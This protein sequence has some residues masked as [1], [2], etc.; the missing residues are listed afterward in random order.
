MLYPIPNPLGACTVLTMISKRRPPS[1]SRARRTMEQGNGGRIERTER[2]NQARTVAD[3]GAGVCARSGTSQVPEDCRAADGIR[4]CWLVSAV[5]SF[6]AP[7]LQGLDRRRD[8]WAGKPQEDCAED[9]SCMGIATMI[10]LLLG[11]SSAR[12]GYSVAMIISFPFSLRWMDVK[13]LKVTGWA[14]KSG[15]CRSGGDGGSGKAH[16]QASDSPT[17]RSARTRQ[18][19][20]GPACHLR[21]IGSHVDGITLQR[22]PDDHCAARDGIST[23]LASWI[24]VL[25]LSS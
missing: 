9:G 19:G 8:S 2:H 23:S 13:K 15:R 14:V 21:T 3:G 18:G 11:Q 10:S 1:E 5:C 24:L 4:G 6:P 7:N 16:S 12:P 25:Y 22:A 20:V 17:V